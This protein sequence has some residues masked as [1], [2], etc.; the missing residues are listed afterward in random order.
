M[1]SIA[2]SIYGHKD[3][4]M[5][6]ALALFG[7]DERYLHSKN[8]RTRGGIVSRTLLPTFS[9]SFAYYNRSQSLSF[10]FFFPPSCT[11]FDLTDIN[12]LIL[13]D[14]GTAKSQFLK[15]VEKTAHRAVHLSLSLS[16][17]YFL[18]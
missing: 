17:L 15:Y 8:H 1:R 13:G 6:L 12:V 10:D 5:A 2:P 11:A 16:S 14:P 4:K 3:V 7:A 9:L 18:I